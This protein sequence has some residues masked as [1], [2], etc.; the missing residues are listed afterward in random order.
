LKSNGSRTLG[1]WLG[2]SA[3][4]EVLDEDTSFL[5]LQ[6]TEIRSLGFIPH[7]PVTVVTT[8][9]LFTYT[10]APQTDYSIFHHTVN[11]GQ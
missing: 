3:S 9:I 11:N 2:C 7:T 6:G 8:L 5:C 4:Q 10:N 1:G